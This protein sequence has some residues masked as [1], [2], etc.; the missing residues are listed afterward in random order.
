VQLC[1]WLKQ[2]PCTS[3]ISLRWLGGGVFY[4]LYDKPKVRLEDCQ[5]YNQNHKPIANVEL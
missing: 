4:E 1:G 3:R 5:N 2:L